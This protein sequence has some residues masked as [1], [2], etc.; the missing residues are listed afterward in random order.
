MAENAKAAALAELIAAEI[1]RQ[2]QE[3]DG[4]G[5]AESIVLMGEAPTINLIELAEAILRA[6]ATSAADCAGL[7]FARMA[8]LAHGSACP[9]AT[10]P[11][12]ACCSVC[13]RVWEG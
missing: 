5:D 1:T 3:H 8:L 11:V 9:R 4:L 10:E 6:P 12:D 2:G 7:T 13:P